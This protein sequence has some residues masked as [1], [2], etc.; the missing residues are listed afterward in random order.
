MGRKIVQLGYGK[1]GKVALDDLLRT[2]HLDELVVA[3]AGPS[4]LPEIA[5]IADPRVRP[6]RLDVGAWEDTV[7]LMRGADVVVELLPIRYTMR[8]AKA[9]VEAGTHMVSSVFIIDWSIQDPE[10]KKRQ[11]E[12]M[13]ELDRTAREKGLTILKEFGMD[14]GIDLII[15]GEA[16]RQLDEVKALYTYGA[17]FP[18]YRLSKA[19]PIGYK[20]TWSIVDT[21]RSYS[22]PGRILRNGEVVEVAADG[23][24]APANLHILDLKEL[25]GPLECFVNGDGYSLAELF[26]SIAKT[27]S[28]LGRFV[29][30]WPGHAAFWEK[31]VKC[32]FVRTRP[33]DVNGVEVIPAE[34]CAA[35]LGSQEQFRYGPGERDVALIRADARGTRNGR[36]TRVGLQLLDYRDLET[37]Y[38]AMQ[39]TVGFP[40][41]IGAQ[42]IMNGTLSKRGIVSPSE[43]PFEP[44]LAEI[45]K[46]GLDITRHVEAWDGSQEPGQAG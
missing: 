44:F 11:Q 30:R 1:M 9:A 17:G 20:F 37:G 45:R 31:M 2:G 25:G 27:A 24:F 41:S 28:S 15:A 18:E 22:L 34:F 16:V 23:M 10:G 13:A 5:R 33:V 46:R 19:N 8:A 35:L 7:N 38:T 36:P 6:V 40:M 21:M 26:P 14:P 39:R 29:C 12:D 42:M 32:G 3:D 43:V 4:F